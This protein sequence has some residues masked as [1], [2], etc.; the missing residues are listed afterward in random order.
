LDPGIRSANKFAA[1]LV[2]ATFLFARSLYGLA[3]NEWRFSEAVDVAR[4]R[5]VASSDY[6]NNRWSQPLAAA[7]I[8]FDF[9]D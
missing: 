6:L 1:G 8:R 2:I 9:I 4:V 5:K 3:P 7:M